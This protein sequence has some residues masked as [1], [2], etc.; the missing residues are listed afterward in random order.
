MKK[1]SMT[2][3]RFHV[4][5]ED[6]VVA[7]VRKS[8]EGRRTTY[9]FYNDPDEGIDEAALFRFYEMHPDTLPSIVRTFKNR[10]SKGFMKKVR[11]REALIKL[12]A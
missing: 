2:G 10:L 11:A 6:E 7:F 1:I 5:Y 9:K 3:D 8:D 12:K 4:N